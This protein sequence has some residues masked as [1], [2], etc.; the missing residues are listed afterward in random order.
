MKNLLSIAALLFISRLLVAQSVTITPGTQGNVQLPRL[1]YNQI[2]A[3]PD[4]QAGMMAFDTTFKCLKYYTGTQWLCTSQT[5]GDGKLAGFAWQKKYNSTL[6]PDRVTDIATD[7]D[8]NVYITGYMCDYYSQ[9]YVAK[10]AADGKLIWEFKDTSINGDGGAWLVLDS[11][12]NVYVTSAV[13]Y[14]ANYQIKV[15]KFQSD[16]SIA[17][18]KS[19]LGQTGNIQ[20]VR[21]I[22]LD[23]GTNVYITGEYS[24]TMT[25][26]P[27]STTAS[28]GRECFVMKLSNGGTPLWVKGVTNNGLIKVNASGESFYAGAFTGNISIEGNNLSSAGDKDILICKYTTAGTLA[29]FK[30][31]G[32]SGTDYVSDLALS[33][34]GEV[35]AIGS[36]SG[37][38]SFD[39]NVTNAVDATDFFAVKYTN[40]G[41][42]EWVR[43]GGGTGDDKG[44][45]IKIGPDNEPVIL[46]SLGGSSGN[47][48]PGNTIYTS[49][50]HTHFLVKYDSLGGYL[51]WLKTVENA[52]GFKINAEND[53]YTWANPGEYIDNPFNPGGY[54]H[55]VT[56]YQSN[57]MFLY[58]QV[59]QGAIASMAFG[60]GKHLF[61][62]GGF[63]Q[64]VQIGTTKLVCTDNQGDIYVSHWVE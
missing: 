64:T 44:I 34:T 50:G 40:A 42:F 32:G 63:A 16:G 1:S 30:Q 58:R 38:A 25:M 62:T 59:N 15:M 13:P 6:A 29:W 57:S 26:T 56:K 31:A 47:F 7:N 43:N 20:A 24:G 23:N 61:F 14:N 4:P 18:Q 45:S 21:G 27:L 39:G 54:N 2:Q 52:A 48:Y 41:F 55:V 51:R 19:T 8:N 5:E 28:V 9:L 37:A 33:N 22:Y 35:Y 12:R 11:N 49:A 53:V 36:F 60:T 17:W 46:G 3:I 10:F